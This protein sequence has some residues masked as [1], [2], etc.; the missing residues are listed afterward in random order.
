[1]AESPIGQGFTKKG[2]Q[3]GTWW[4][5]TQMVPCRVE[6]NKSKVGLVFSVGCLAYTFPISDLQN[7]HL[8]VLL[9]QHSLFEQL[10]AQFRTVLRF[11]SEST[12]GSPKMIKFK[13]SGSVGP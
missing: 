12:R 10:F 1:M 13:K 6:I 4:D 9:Y 3:E 8:S 2:N 5:V 11:K 7:L